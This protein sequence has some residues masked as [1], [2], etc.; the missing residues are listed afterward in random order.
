MSSL[1]KTKELEKIKKELSEDRIPIF[2]NLSGKAWFK[3]TNHELQKELFALPDDFDSFLKDLSVRPDELGNI[4][5]R[6]LLKLQR[7]SYLVIPVFEVRSLETNEVYTYEYAS[8]KQGK[9]P[10]YRGIFLVRK[11]SKIKYFILRKAFKFSVAEAIYESMGVFPVTF[12][13][14]KLLQLPTSLEKRIVKILGITDVQ[15]RRFIDLGFVLPDAGLSNTH[16]NI[17]AAIIDIDD[18][19]RL[20][21]HIGIKKLDRYAPG[22]ELEIHPIEDMLNF[23]G[24]VDDS[25]FL[26]IVSRLQALNIIEL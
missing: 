26:S 21:K 10:G 17:F 24:K 2:D 7:G 12:S 23:I 19:S 6:K 16:T 11:D 1:E 20:Q 22:Y 18:M 3:R 25:F 14:D 4:E 15:I 8:W 5:V 13:R 9:Y